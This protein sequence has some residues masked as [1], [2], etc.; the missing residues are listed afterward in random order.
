MLPKTLVALL[1]FA[2]VGC[3]I[4]A[5]TPTPMLLPPPVVTAAPLS[6]PTPTS[7]I[8][9]LP[10]RLSTPD[11]SPNCPERIAWFFNNS[12]AECAGQALTTWAVLQRFERGVMVWFQEGGRTFILHDDGSLLRPVYEASDGSDTPLPQADPNIV[13]P[14]GM[15][16]PVLGFGKFWRGLVPG[17]EWVRERLGWATAP[18][19]GYSALLQCNTAGGPAA[20]CYFTGPRDEVLVMTRGI[21]RY[22]NYWQG[23]VR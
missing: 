3:G 23:P 16:Q 6:P 2:L 21:D 4:N 7:F 13:P 1:A 17:Y 20:R 5:A 8:E 9:G 19:L 22:W 15:Y 12:V 11:P 14:Q 18:E 10:A